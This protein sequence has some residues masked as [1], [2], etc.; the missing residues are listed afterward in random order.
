MP[1]SHPLPTDSAFI[2]RY[3]LIDINKGIDSQA[4][5]ELLLSCMYVLWYVWREIYMCIYM[6]CIHI[7]AC[8]CV[9]VEMSTYA[10]VLGASLFCGW[11]WLSG[12]SSFEKIWGA[13][14]EFLQH[15]A[16]INHFFN[17]PETPSQRTA[18]K[19]RYTDTQLYNAKKK[20]KKSYRLTERDG[21]A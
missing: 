7:Y 17:Q 6:Q 15:H 5:S 11:L 14:R 21:V 12:E 10:C 16:P 19:H 18:D 20:K 4:K 3:I 1:K 8:V 2:C 9:Y 13:I